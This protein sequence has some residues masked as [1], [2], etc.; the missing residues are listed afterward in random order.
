MSKV[1]ERA[2]ERAPLTPA[3]AGRFLWGAL[4]TPF[5]V[6]S[7]L[8]PPALPGRREATP[9]ADERTPLILRQIDGLRETIWRQRRAILGFRGLWLALLAADLWLG[10]RVLAGRDLS[11][12]PFALVAFALVALAAFLIAT[13]RPSRGQMARTLDR[14]FGLRERLTTAV[15]EAQAGRPSGLRALQMLDATRVTRHITTATA[16]RPHL[17]AREIAAAL[18]TGIFCLV[19]VIMLIMQHFGGPGVGTGAGAA[20][21]AGAGQGAGNA[22]GSQAGS[23]AG[24]QAG[25]GGR[26]GQNSQARQGGQQGSGQQG[27]Q[28]TAQ[29]KED[30]NTVAGALQDHASTSAAGDKLASGDY[31]GAAGALREAGNNAAQTSPQERQTIANDVRNAAD[32]VGDPQL[33]SDLRDVANGLAQ[34]N[35]AGAQ[36]A[37]GRVAN[38][39]DRTAQGGE[40]SGTGQQGQQGQNGQQGNN[41]GT[42]AGTGSTGNGVSP[43]LPSGQQQ[44]PAASSS[45]LLGADGKPIEL[46]KGD[47]SGQLI[48]TQDKQ[49]RT[50]GAVDPG[51]AGAGG[52]TVQQGTVGEAGVDTNQVPYDQR[53]TVER[54]FTPNSD[55]GR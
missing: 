7:T 24:Q 49:G 54:Y 46:P 12:R 28:P 37:F 23:Q 1:I 38:D 55:D 19:F 51:A 20:Q 53:G 13:A 9:A 31:A 26:P 44:S 45:P 34:P 41:G 18:A 25:Q 15:E 16:F 43:Q 48:T 8:P 30:M 52:G 50:G 14:S 39:V 17:P 42:G 33:A 40:P 5:W 35:A 10:L 36:Q 3:R 47:P 32:Q 2:P 21:G 22:F 27:G 29:G 4:W 6:G 11:P